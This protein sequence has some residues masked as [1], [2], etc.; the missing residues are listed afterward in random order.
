M[1]KITYKK[2]EMGCLIAAMVGIVVMVATKDLMI[3]ILSLFILI[4]GTDLGK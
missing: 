2:I 4:V 3:G 1:N